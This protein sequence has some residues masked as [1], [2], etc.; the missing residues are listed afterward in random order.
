MAAKNKIGVLVSGGGTNLQSLID[1]IHQGQC[2]AEI[3]CV[4][5]NV[6][7]AY[8]LQRASDANI[9]ALLINHKDYPDRQ[10][11]ELELINKLQQHQTTIVCLAGFMRV[12]ESTFIHAFE[13]KILNIHPSLLP[14]FTGLHTHQRALDAHEKS[15][16]CSVHFATRE[17]DGGPVILQARVPVF[18]E[19]N[20]DLLASRVLEK[21]HVIYPLCVQ[22]LCENRIHYSNGLAYY[23]N[24]PLHKPLLLDEL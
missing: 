2:D 19:D 6:P 24:K 17:L 1:T 10:Q 23:E 5:S 14:K 4:I 12:L 7:E 15:H 3:A 22:W 16:G 13:G 8:A 20:A 11:F 18:E 9:P 21:E